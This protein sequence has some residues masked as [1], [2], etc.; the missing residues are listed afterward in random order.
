MRNS[1]SFA[2]WILV[3]GGLE[4]AT[5]ILDRSHHLLWARGGYVLLKTSYFAFSMVLLV[6]FLSF[7]NRRTF[8][9]MAQTYHTLSGQT[10][11]TSSG[12]GDDWRKSI[13]HMALVVVASANMITPVAWGDVTFRTSILLDLAFWLLAL[14]W[15]ARAQWLKALGQREKLKEGLDDARSLGS[16]PMHKPGAG[17]AEVDPAPADATLGPATSRRPFLALFILMLAA[18]AAL[19]GWRWVTADKVYHHAALKGCLLHCLDRALDRF[20]RD[21]RLDE[22]I[23]REACLSRYREQVEIGM[24]FQRGELL[25][26]TIEKPGQD[27]FGNG[28]PGDQGLMLDAAGRFRT[29]G[30]GL[31]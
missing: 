19:S 31:R 3:L 28:K 25:L 5:V 30:S 4:L 27:Y 20:H 26:W 17:P 13:F 16:G 9:S 12:L 8:E 6:R 21:G 24:G 22:G 1:L 29:T 14:R 10:W 11:V 2:W 18:T 23:Q 7:R 15:V